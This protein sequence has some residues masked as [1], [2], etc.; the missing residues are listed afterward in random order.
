MLNQQQH[1]GGAYLTASFIREHVDICAPVLS[2]LFGLASNTATPPADDSW[3]RDYT[4]KLAIEFIDSLRSEKTLAA[5]R[6]MFSGA[7]PE[8]RVADIA[9]ALNCG[10]TDL[11][12][13]WAGMTRVHRRIM[14]E[15]GS[16]FGKWDKA[17]YV[18]GKYADQRGRFSDATWHAFRQAL[19]L[20]PALA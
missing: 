12:G 5:L 4:P 13:V 7:T 17:E 14:G 11:N 1:D 8:C 10:V 18:G 19:G 9:K 15:P 16:S 20:E 2:V 3:P 6:A